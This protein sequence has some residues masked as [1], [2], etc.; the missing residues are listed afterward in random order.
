MPYGPLFKL[1]K[2]QSDGSDE[3]NHVCIPM[4]WLC[5]AFFFAWSKIIRL[6]LRGGDAS[7]Y[8]LTFI[9][10]PSDQG[11]KVLVSGTSTR[12]KARIGLEVVVMVDAT[13]KLNLGTLSYHVFSG[14]N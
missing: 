13:L 5:F 1:L 7:T 9:I 8:R 12:R 14:Q 2:E 4:L 11:G 6:I 3:N 10:T